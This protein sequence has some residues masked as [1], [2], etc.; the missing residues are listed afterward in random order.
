MYLGNREYS[1]SLKA[2]HRMPYTKLTL[3]ELTDLLVDK[4]AM[5]INLRQEDK[6]TPEY[7][8][9]VSTVREQLDQIQNE[10]I[11]RNKGPHK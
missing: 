10:I 5:L 7:I 6:N 4:V 3:Q 8:Q 9:N 2:G 11:R 1:V